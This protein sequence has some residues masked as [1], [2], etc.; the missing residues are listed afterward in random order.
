MD[1][2]IYLNHLLDLIDTI[3][4]HFIVLIRLLI[5]R[6]R[7]CYLWLAN[8]LMCGEREPFILVTN[9]YWQLKILVN[10]VR[11]AIKLYLKLWLRTLLWF[12]II[13]DKDPY[14][15][16]LGVWS[17]QNSLYDLSGFVRLLWGVDL[18]IRDSSMKAEL[19]ASILVCVHSEIKLEI[20]PLCWGSSFVRSSFVRASLVRSSFRRWLLT[21]YFRQVLIFF[22][23]VKQLGQAHFFIV[24]RL[25]VLLEGKRTYRAVD[26][27]SK[28]ITVN[29]VAASSEIFFLSFI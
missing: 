12:F 6:V 16:F 23:L 25:Q 8:A 11:H 3:Q 26:T 13:H 15:P 1:S 20:W 24:K 17:I 7:L 28:L 18:G 21:L 4:H 2:I 14:M 10:D 29:N 27:G 22:I 9:I 5:R 19:L